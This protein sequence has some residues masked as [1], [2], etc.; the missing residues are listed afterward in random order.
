MGILRLTTG[1]SDNSTIRLYNGV[2]QTL[3]YD[4]YRGDEIYRAEA[5]IRIP[6]VTSVIFEFGFRDAAGDNFIELYADTDTASSPN[7]WKSYVE[8]A[9]VATDT[10]TGTALSANA[11]VTLTI[12]QETLGTVDFYIDDVLED[13]RTT[14]IPDSETMGLFFSVGTRTT[15]T[16]AFDI[17][18][19]SFESQGMGARTT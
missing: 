16:R 12:L 14:N 11:W 9:T 15:A 1:A 18:Y 6:T 5:I 13:T 4:T 10:D 17:D 2:A 7:N 8:E 3:G 19:C